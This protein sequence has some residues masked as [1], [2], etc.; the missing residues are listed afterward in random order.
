VDGHKLFI[1]CLPEDITQEEL[2][3]VFG[4]YG[5]VIHLHIMKQ[6]SMTGLRAAFVYYSTRDAGEDAIKVLNNVY[7][8]RVDATQ[9][10]QVR[11]GMDKDQGGMGKGTD[12]LGASFKVFVGNLPP[13]CNEDELRTCFGTYGEVTLVHMLPPHDNTGSKAALIF[14]KERYSGEDAIR[15]LDGQYKIRVDSTSPIVVKW[16]KDKEQ[17]PLPGAWD[18]GGWGKGPWDKGAWDKGYGKGWGADPYMKG[19]WDKGW[20]KGWDDWKGCGKGWDKGKGWWDAK[21]WDDGKGK[22]AW[23]MGKGKSPMPPPEDPSGKLYVANL[24]VDIADQALEYVFGAY[25]KVERVHIM[26]NK[27]VNGGVAAFVEFASPDEAETAIATLSGK[28]EIR[29]GQGPILVRHANPK[30]PRPY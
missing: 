8:I 20:G 13:D 17:K 16:G 14:Y 5:E 6:N 29:A 23:D 18:K 15:L 2:K 24:P 28:Y 26:N 1:G 12:P 10:I 22:G 30:R 25:G 7:K 4:T 27:S 9:P 3:T 11:W 19:G 21:G